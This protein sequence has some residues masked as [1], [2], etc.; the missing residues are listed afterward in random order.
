[1]GKRGTRLPLSSHLE[2]PHKNLHWQSHVASGEESLGE[3]F[4]L[5]S[6]LSQT[7]ERD[8]EQAAKTV[9]SFEFDQEFETAAE[10]SDIPMTSQPSGS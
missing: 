8:K 9:F 1:M 2:N 6:P 5:G 3:E 4:D 7:I 10:S